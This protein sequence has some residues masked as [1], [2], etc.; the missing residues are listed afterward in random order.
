MKRVIRTKKPT[1]A[2][3]RNMIYNLRHKYSQHAAIDIQFDAFTTGN[4][5]M[6]FWFWVKDLIGEHIDTWQELQDKYF[7]L[8][9]DAND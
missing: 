5:K 2:Q 8:I 7:A 1:T 9:G 3:I 4:T 6:E